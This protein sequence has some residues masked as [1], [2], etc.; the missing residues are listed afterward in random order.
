[1]KRVIFLAL[2]IMV[3]SFAFGSTNIVENIEVVAVVSPDGGE[4]TEINATDLPKA[5][6][7]A[8][9][10]SDYRG[11]RAEEKAHLVKKADGSEFYKITL[12][13]AASGESKTIKMDKEGK[14]IKK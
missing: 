2:S 14:E 11:W 9:A 4:Q 1:M 8:L 7:D 6:R 3:M 13:N 5:V 12:V 10:S